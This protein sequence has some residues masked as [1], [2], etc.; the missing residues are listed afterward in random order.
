[1]LTS[2]EAVYNLAYELYIQQQQDVTALQ[3]LVERLSAQLDRATAAQLDAA[4]GAALA[5]T[6][7]HCFDVG[8]WLGRNPD[9]LLFRQE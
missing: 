8:L 7:R 2:N 1:M 6:E 9:A 4:V 3:A 5:A